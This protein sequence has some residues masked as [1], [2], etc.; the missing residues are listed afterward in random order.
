MA[1]LRPAPDPASAA[2]PEA[3]GTGL[4]AHPD[5]GADEGVGEGTGARRAHVA[6]LLFALGIALLCTLLQGT[7]LIEALRFD[8]HRIADGAWWRLL[9]GNFVHLG[10]SHLVMNL[11]GL[12]LVVALVWRRF[13]ALEWALVTLLSS[14]SVGAGL[15]A[16]NP[17]I[18]WYVGFSG[19]LHGLLVAGCLADLR[20][21]PK[22]AAALLALIGGKLAWEQLAGALP[23]SEAT[24]GGRVVVDAHLYGAIGGLL[25]APPLL[26]RRRR[27]AR[28]SGMARRRTPPAGDT[29]PP[30]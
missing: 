25:L 18:G 14:L 23:G 9:S 3:T 11:A 5:G 16:L 6:A 10:T 24:A 8:R 27:R 2:K 19:T 20:H 28:R 7:G 17:T 26:W 1:R 4:A 13:G 12:A 15:Y 30:P 22:S 21:F 29:A